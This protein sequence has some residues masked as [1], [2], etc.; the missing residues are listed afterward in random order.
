MCDFKKIISVVIPVVIFIVVGLFSYSLVTGASLNAV[1]G[2]TDLMKVFLLAA[3]LSVGLNML[4]D[5]LI[6]CKCSGGC[7]C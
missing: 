4:S 2:N 1:F 5:S 6:G 3:V 7:T